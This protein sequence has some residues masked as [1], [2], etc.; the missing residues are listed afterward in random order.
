VL[1]LLAQGHD[2]AAIAA[3]LYVSQS[4]VKHHISHVLDKLGVTNRVQAAALAIRHG[5]DRACLL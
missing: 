4:T 1:G 3:Q 5:L 2:N